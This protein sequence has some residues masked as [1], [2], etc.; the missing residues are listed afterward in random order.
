MVV[1]RPKYVPKEKIIMIC[2][3]SSLFGK[4]GKDPVD[5][6]RNGKLYADKL[7]EYKYVHSW[8]GH[9]HLNFN[10]VYAKTSENRLPNVEGH[11]V[12]RATGPCG[13]TSGYVPTVRRADTIS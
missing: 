12:A 5:V 9:S 13:S 1:Q 11:I 6:D 4:P 2:S 7:S 8:A 3:H 10:K